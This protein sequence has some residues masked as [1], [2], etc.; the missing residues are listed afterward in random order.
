[1]RDEPEAITAGDR[2]RGVWMRRS[3]VA[4]CAALFVLVSVPAA[5]SG[6]IGVDEA[7]ALVAGVVVVEEHDLRMV[8]E[9]GAV[10]RTLAGLLPAVATDVDVRTG[11]TYDDGDWFAHS[12]EVVASLD[13]DGSLQSSLR[14]MRIVPILTALAVGGLLW[15]LGSMVGSPWA[16]AIAASLWFCTP[17][18]AGLAALTSLDVTYTAGVLLVVVAGLRY[19]GSPT[20]PNLALIGG[21]I[22]VV[23]SI[24]HHSLVLGVV[25]LVAIALAAPAAGQPAREV[26][27]RLAGA[28]VATIVAIWAIHL[29]LDPTPPTG[30]IAARFDGLIGTASADSLPA[31]LLLALPLPDT[32]RAGLA[33]QVVNGFERDAYAFGESWQGGRWWFLPVTAATKISA[34]ALVLLVAGVAVAVARIRDRR[35]A[36]IGTATVV[37]ALFELASPINLGFRH[38]LPLLALTYLAAAAGLERLPAPRASAVAPLAIVATMAVAMVAASG[39]P[40]AWT[41]PPFS[42]GYRYV[43]DG[44]LDFG[45]ANGSV[46]ARHATHPFVAGSFTAT[47]GFEVLPG[48][49]AVLGRP[50]AELVGDIAVSGATLTVRARDELS[51]LRAHCPVEVIGRAVLVYRF[52]RPPDTSPGPPMPVAPCLG[53]E[54]SLRTG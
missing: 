50:A 3:L 41:T 18:V 27:Q 25:A 47:V 6:S 16:G 44:S 36:L 24:R 19:V 12:A 15:R 38:A 32:W 52:D 22:G 4:A 1:M 34:P 7:S 29:G 35:W 39:T 51:W 17:Y 54:V 48:V 45:Q 28:G 42:D 23:A 33:F 46:R 10:H 37:L 49:P 11:Q 43:S 40:L 13:R 2:S 8:P 26:A 30:A 53:A 21:A 14:W 5:W 31:R 9:H 20:W